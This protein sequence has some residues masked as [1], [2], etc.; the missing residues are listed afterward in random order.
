MVDI[1][2]FGEA[3]VEVMRTDIGQPLSEPNPF[4][5]PFPSGAPFI[6]A[7]QAAQLGLSVNAIG[8]VG[9]D[10]FGQCQRDYMEE[11][12]VQTHDIH[13]S[14][15]HTTGVAFVGYEADGSREF[16]FHFAH[17]AA[18]Q[19]HPD[20]LHPEQFTNLRCIHISG[21]S[22]AIHDNALAMGMRAI[23][24][25]K[26]ADA[27][28][29]FDP[30]IREQLI[31]L[32][33]AKEI[34]MPFLESADVFIP[35]TAELCLLMQTDDLQDAARRFTQDKVDTILIASNG[36]KGALVWN[37]DSFDVIPG[38]A[39]HEVDPTGAGDCFNAGFLAAHLRGAS[40]SEA[41]RFANACAAL[42][43]TIQGPMAGIHNYK[44][45]T[46]FLEQHPA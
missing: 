14:T 29:S 34:Y 31:S 2:T 45:V 35:T 38:F 40:N 1:L 18:G 3:L 12:G 46:Q 6:F 8:T 27:Q 23:Q 37:G 30:N 5:G 32:E 33:R 15:D 9:D 44:Q 41:T 17:S 36:E 24:L 39:T 11:M 28:I 25:A 4:I 26:E 13:I 16:V 19:L 10:A 43:I 7:V 42:S 20:M 22:L 21:S